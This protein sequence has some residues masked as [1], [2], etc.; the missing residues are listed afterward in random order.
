MASGDL[1]LRFLNCKSGFISTGRHPNFSPGV[2]A[3]SKIASLVRSCGFCNISSAL[4]FRPQNPEEKENA[5]SEKRWPRAT[6]H[7][8]GSLVIQSPPVT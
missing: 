3:T 7:S 6:I 4:Q 8:R 2:N 5:L 1:L